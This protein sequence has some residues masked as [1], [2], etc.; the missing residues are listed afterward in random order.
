MAE[1]H[2]AVAFSFNVTPEGVDVKYNHEAIKAVWFSGVH[3]W[4]LRFIRFKVS[5]FMIFQL[6]LTFSRILINHDLNMRNLLEV[7]LNWGLLSAI[8]VNTY[9]EPMTL[10]QL[11][12]T[13]CCI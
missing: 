10:I 11:L 8:F 9:S 2:A 13:L 4:K 3:S 5:D 6:I 1:A 7:A 12:L